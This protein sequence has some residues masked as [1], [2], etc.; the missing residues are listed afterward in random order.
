MFPTSL[1]RDAKIIEERN[2]Y[3]KLINL[4]LMIDE[5]LKSIRDTIN[6]RTT[7]DKMNATLLAQPIFSDFLKILLINPIIYADY[8]IK[9]LNIT[10]E[11]KSSEVRC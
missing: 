5:S 6:R 3:D 1:M 11:I 2:L 7:A 9:W 4:T 8:S 10:G